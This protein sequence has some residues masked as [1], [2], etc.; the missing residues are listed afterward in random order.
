VVVLLGQVVQVEPLVVVVQVEVEEL[1][2]Q[3][4]VVVQVEHQVVEGHL[5]LLVHLVHPVLPVEKVVGYL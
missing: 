4:E 3:V 5:E 1:L 2:A